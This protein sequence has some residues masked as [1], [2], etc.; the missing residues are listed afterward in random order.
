MLKQLGRLERT[1]N[2][3][4]LGFA[5]L[6]AVSLVIFYAPNR[7]ATTINPATSTEV[8]AKVGSDAIT[9]ADLMLVREGLRQRYG[10]QIPLSTL[11]DNR[12]FLESLIAKYVIQHEADRLGLSASDAEVR[13]RIVRQFT[14]AS[15]V[16]VGAE[17]YKESVT[18]RYGSVEKFENELR[19]EIAL[20]K[21][22]AFIASS[23]NVSDDEVQQQYKRKETAF[24]IGYVVLTPDK[25]AEKIQLTES[26]LRSYYD[27]HKTDLRYL[28]P[29]RKVRYI[30]LDQEKAAS[31][32]QI[33]DQELKAEYD[34]LQPEFKQAGVKVQQIVLKVAR[35]DLD[36]Q[37]EQKA[38]DLIAKLRGSS[39]RATEAAF[40]EA[41]K[42]NSEDPATASNGGFLPNLVKKNPNK[43]H[44]L[45]DRAV[46]M[47]VGDVS[48]IPIRYGG[49][50]YIL[51]RGDPVMKTF[52]AAKQE[53]L[54]SL[55]N[56]RSYS[57]ALKVATKAYQRLKETKDLQK[58][59]Q[60]VASQ[61]NMTPAEMIKETPY[62]KP[63]DD[64]KDIGNNQQFHDVVSKLNNPNDIAEPTS[65]K[66]GFA[67]PIFVDKKEPRIPEFDEVRTQIGDLVKKQRAK[68]ELEQKAKTI[69]ALIPSPDGMKAA[70][71]KEGFEA[72]IIEKFKLGQPLG[73]A[74]SPAIDEAIYAM[75]IGEMTKAPVKVGDDW[76]IF[77]VVK[78]YDADLSGFANQRDQVRQT[79]LGERQ[80]QVFQDYIASVHQR[81]KRD[82]KIKVYD[83]VLNSI[84]V[85]E[86]PAAVPGLPPGLNFPT[87]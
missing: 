50:W 49:N 12:S 5:I 21:L 46:D 27:S 14:D 54:V 76:V 9:V 51:R 74:S 57:E 38:K 25:L 62:I 20:E 65:I 10:G 64:V 22:R 79:M 48:D 8:V 53:I 26:D 87:K 55:R 58:V 47:Q 3:I 81:M 60:E 44:G 13:D 52:E 18:P 68:D 75:N 69:L 82:G 24:D 30:Y 29:Q 59:A 28:E 39:G 85:E 31:K 77:G 56:R 16:F 83:D 32:V 40:T 7:S 66:G 34:K 17:R 36:S 23:V 42:G 43:P 35:K 84:A 73:E 70:G 15:G 6:M 45:Y 67:V 61:A 78:K 19:Q 80:S 4:I 2:I 1:R 33:S 37:V 63:G 86:E 72:D 41:A 11:G 71:E